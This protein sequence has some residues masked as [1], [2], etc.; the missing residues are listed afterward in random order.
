MHVY[1]FSIL[2]LIAVD[3]G[4]LDNPESGQVILNGTIFMS[5]ATYSCM[6][7]YVL[8]GE[9]TRTCQANG[10]WSGRA[11]FCRR[12]SDYYILFI[13]RLVA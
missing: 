2:N 1:H 6:V 3:C 7:G 10:Q 13:I 5:T 12:K 9:Q 8:V 4:D 11:P